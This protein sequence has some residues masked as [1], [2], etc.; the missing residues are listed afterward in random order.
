MH[1]SIADALAQIRGECE[2]S[3]PGTMLG[4][5][6]PGAAADGLA[7]AP[8]AIG[9][10]RVDTE[11]GQGASAMLCTFRE[12]H[13]RNGG[14]GTLVRYTL[15]KDAGSAGTSV[16]TIATESSTPFES[17]F[18]DEGDAPGDD[19]PGIPRPRGSRR[20]FSASLDGEPYGVRIYEARTALPDTVAAQDADMVA[21]GWVSSSAVAGAFADA[22]SYRRGGTQVIASFNRVGEA[23]TVTFSV[24]G[25][26]GG[27]TSKASGELPGGLH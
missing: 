16:F 6:E 23:T 3:S 8:E 11:H 15:V 10:E 20:V 4:T 12:K 14:S 7:V 22:R 25:T 5:G 26:A 2:S 1:G 21:Q 17:L 24:D 27:A 19:L 18:P 13:P 9:L